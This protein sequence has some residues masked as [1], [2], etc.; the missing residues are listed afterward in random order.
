MSSIEECRAGLARMSERIR[1]VDEAKRRKHISER[2][3][4]VLVSDLGT[5]F[6]MRLTVNGLE[7]ITSRGTGT[8]AGPR[9]QVRITVTSDDLVELAEDRLD[10][11]KALLSGRVKIDASLGDMLRMRKLL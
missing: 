9:S 2:S 7:E 6:D 8:A 11:A 5:V 1:E 10:T 3:V 4:S